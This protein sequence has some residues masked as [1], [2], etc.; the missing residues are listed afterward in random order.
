MTEQ[1]VRTEQ[2]VTSAVAK[3]NEA[4]GIIARYTT[5]FANV[6][7][8]HV[9]PETFVRLSQGVLRRDPKLADVAQRNP[10]SFLSALLDCA[11]LGHGPG[12][13]QYYLVPFG[14]E[15]Q[16]IEGY[17]GVIERIYRAG[18]VSSVVCEVVREGDRFTYTPGRDRMPVHEIDWDA[19]DEGPLK[20]AYAYA[21]MRDGSV[22][23]VVVLRKAE[24]MRHKAESKT[25]SRS[26]SMWVKW[27]K[28]AWLKTVARELEK[29]VPSSSE[30][31]REQLRAAVE[32]DNLRQQPPSELVDVTDAEIV[33]NP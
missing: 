15:I 17:R 29:W 25:S 9:K 5:D 31:M 30:F 7:P 1:T 3:R 23:R 13:E 11:R 22:S 21:W 24:V 19:E 26:D 6:L 33:D 18:A 16:G 28:S 8:S 27:E 14:S 4:E 12:T 2:T 10:G 32:A 20:L